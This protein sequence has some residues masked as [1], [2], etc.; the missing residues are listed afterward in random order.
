MPANKKRNPVL[1][2]YR[3]MAVEINGVGVAACVAAPCSDSAP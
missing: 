2:V 1:G 3:C